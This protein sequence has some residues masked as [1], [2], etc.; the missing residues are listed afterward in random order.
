[1]Q[2]ALQAFIHK[3][4]PSLSLPLYCCTAFFSLPSCYKDRFAFSLWQRIFSGNTFWG[5]SCCSWSGSLLISFY[6]LVLHLFF[7]QGC[8]ICTPFLTRVPGLTVVTSLSYPL[9]SACFLDTW[10]SDCLFILVASFHVPSTSIIHLVLYIFQISRHSFSFA[11]LA[12]AV[13]CKGRLWACLVIFFKFLGCGCS[14]SKNSMVKDE[15][16]NGH[17]LPL[18]TFSLPASLCT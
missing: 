10:S 4:A 2:I 3:V 15:K 5:I 17:P 7:R 1:M 6:S 11:K 8:L 9:Y 13:F 14:W 12:Q 16:N 18:H